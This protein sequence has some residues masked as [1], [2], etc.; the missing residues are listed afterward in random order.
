MERVAEVAVRLE[1]AR[2]ASVSFGDPLELSLDCSVCRRCRRTVV[3]REGRAEGVCIPTGHPSPVVDAD[4]RRSAGPYTSDKST[5]HPGNAVNGVAPEPS[6]PGV[7]ATFM[8]QQT[9]EKY[10]IS[11][12]SSMAPGS[13]RRCTASA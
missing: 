3:F 4:Q 13:P 11:A 12:A 8:I 1:F 7:R 2:G 6:G 10:P 5:H 9:I